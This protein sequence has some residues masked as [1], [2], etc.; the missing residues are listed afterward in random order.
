MFQPNLNINDQFLKVVIGRPVME[1][2]A[3]TNTT[4]V[5]RLIETNT[6]MTLERWADVSQ[7]EIAFL[8]VLC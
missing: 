8:A 5:K 3:E 6:P 4:R 1:V 2:T 7:T